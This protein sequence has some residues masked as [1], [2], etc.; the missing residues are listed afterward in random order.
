MALPRLNETIKYNIKIPSTGQE[1]RY[2]PFLI[3]E[4]KV[5]LLAMESQDSKM[6]LNSILDTITAC[7]EEQ[8]NFSILP[9]FDIEYIFLQIRSKSV[10]E[11][12]DVI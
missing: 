3:K 10:G 11:N 4:E 1:I 9:V 7:V 8:I 2:R 6:I 12:S 5:L